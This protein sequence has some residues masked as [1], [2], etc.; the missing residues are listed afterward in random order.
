VR[1]VRRIAS[2]LSQ[3][4]G[5]DPFPDQI[6]RLANMSVKEVEDLLHITEQP[7]SLDVPTDLDNHFMLADILEDPLSMEPVSMVTQ[8]LLSEDM[9]RA[10]SCL[11]QR[12]RDV[13]RL[14]YGIGDVYSRRLS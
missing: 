6:V 13:I 5:Q 10:F 2:Q 1:K 8:H 3:E 14:Q 12:E 11:T 9:Y 7:I 4:N